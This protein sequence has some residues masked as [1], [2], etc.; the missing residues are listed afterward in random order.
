MICS[1][2][3]FLQKDRKKLRENICFTISN[4]VRLC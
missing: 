4:M 2:L 3:N 1:F